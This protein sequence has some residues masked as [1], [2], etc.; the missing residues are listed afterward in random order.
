[1]IFHSVFPTILKRL[2][3]SFLGP[4]P[5]FSNKYYFFMSPFP[6]LIP[7]V[8]INSQAEPALTEKSIYAKIISIESEN[9][10]Q[11]NS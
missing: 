8:P 9:R 3:I 4:F 5:F 2:V 6:F 10:V 1:M 11:P 7:T